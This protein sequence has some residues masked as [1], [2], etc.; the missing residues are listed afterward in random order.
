MNRTLFAGLSMALSLCSAS[1]N[2]QDTLSIG[3]ARSPQRAVTVTSAA[4]EPDWFNK[5]I[6][7]DFRR[8]SLVDAVK[9]ILDAA[10]VKYD[11]VEVSFDAPKT[12]FDLK[13]KDINARDALAAM[14]RFGGA[15]AYVSQEDGK[16]VIE[17][18]KRTNETA[19][20]QSNP[21]GG[22]TLNTPGANAFSGLTGL[23]R[24]SMLSERYKDLPEKKIDLDVREGSVVDVLK[25]ITQ[26]AGIAYEL[27]DGLKSDAKL[28][29]SMKEA[30]VGSA[31][32]MIA[33]LLNA[34]WKPEKKDGKVKVT[35][36]KKLA[37][38]QDMIFTTPPSTSR[39]LVPTPAMP[40]FGSTL[41]RNALP[42]TRVSLDK[43][44][45]DP[46]EIL[47]D[48]LKQANVAYAIGDDLPSEPKS[49]TFENVPL[50][51]ALNMICESIGASWTTERGTDG[52]P[53]VRIGKAGRAPRTTSYDSV[54]QRYFG[55]RGERL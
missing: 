52:K 42:D 55:P 18:R 15:Q 10:K 17:L 2:A 1:V 35:F 24:M 30:T 39:T 31:L 26:Q 50:T 49:F 9:K 23:P 40:S 7:I 28:T 8:L 3:Q 41:F 27:E 12:K 32:D 54:I 51:T 25:A 5:S 47:R 38:N 6:D 45:T 29:L 34:G 16:T 43:K 4:A 36:S 44:K 46:R 20:V 14:A 22:F 53:L 19:L 21:F 37:R 11:K 48:V 33:R 13:A